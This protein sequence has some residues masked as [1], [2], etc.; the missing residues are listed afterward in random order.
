MHLG[1]RDG[2]QGHHELSEAGKAKID[3]LA[4]ALGVPAA[5]M[6]T[7][8]SAA[9]LLDLVYRMDRRDHHRDAPIREVLARTGDNWSTLIL[10]VL[11][12]GTFRHATLRRLIAAISAERAISQRMLTLRLRALERDGMVRRDVTP[13]TPPRV[14]Y[15]LTPLG[16]E[17]VV[18]IEGLLSW[19]ERNDAQ[20]QESRRNFEANKL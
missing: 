5:K 6:E 1:A 11:A 10:L 3:A 15:S 19:I 2:T 17:L 14:D 12:A 8:P 4:N 9:V 16:G 18:L 20:I 13:T 7:I